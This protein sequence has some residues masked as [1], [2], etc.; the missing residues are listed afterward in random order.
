MTGDSSVPKPTILLVD[1]ELDVRRT[2]AG[3]LT[4]GGYNVLTAGSG[5]QAI[6]SYK[7][8]GSPV[9]LLLSDVVA[10]GMSGPMIAD[11]LLEEQPGLRV[12]FISG[13]DNTQVVQR[14]V[15]EKGFALL[16]KPFTI[17]QLQSKVREVL[18]APPPEPFRGSD[19]VEIG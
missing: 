13:Y 9:D 15:V 4:A 3:M 19:G 6:R 17:D 18:A 11:A 12:L 7:K 14:Y 10:P 1:D 8:H 16:P 5:E 2:V